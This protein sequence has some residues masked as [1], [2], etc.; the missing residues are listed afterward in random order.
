MFTSRVGGQGS[1]PA[2]AVRI[3]TGS[4]HTSD[5][6]SGTPVACQVPEDIGSALRLVGLV[7]VYC[8]WVRE[9]V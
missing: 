8:D 9:K 4:S 6:K 5:L 7:S 1:T 2:F 3:F